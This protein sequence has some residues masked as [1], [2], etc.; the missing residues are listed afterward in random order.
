MWTRSFA[1]IL[2]HRFAKDAMKQMT[3]DESNWDCE[4]DYIRIWERK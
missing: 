1:K 3:T 4:I 2:R